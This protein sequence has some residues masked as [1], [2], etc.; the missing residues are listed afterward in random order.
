[1]TALEYDLVVIGSGSAGQKCA[2]AAAKAGKRVAVIDRTGMI[3]GV[4]VHTGTIPGKTV[5]EAIFQLSGLAISALYGGG[6]RR[7]VGISVENVSSRVKAIVARET[8]VV[9]AQLERNGIV[10][11]PGDA[12]FLD[13]HTVEVQSDG[14]GTTVNGSKILIA[15]PGQRATGSMID[16]REFMRKETMQTNYAIRSSRTIHEVV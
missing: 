15:G 16:Q 4:S 3:G 14:E 2:V 12:R 6:P 5:R 13:P 11:Y 9:R 7:R 10:I 8:E 1:V